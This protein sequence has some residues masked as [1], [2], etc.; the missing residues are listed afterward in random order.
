M[1]I[2]SA[3]ISLCV[4]NPPVAQIT[5]G[6]PAWRDSNAEFVCFTAAISLWTNSRSAGKK[7]PLSAQL[8]LLNVGRYFAFALRSSFHY[9]D[10]PCVLCD[11]QCS[12]KHKI[13]PSPSKVT[14]KPHSMRSVASTPIIKK[15]IML[16]IFIHWYAPIYMTSIKRRN[17]NNFRYYKNQYS[18]HVWIIITLSPLNTDLIPNPTRPRYT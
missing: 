13:Q 16:E 3:W 15:D 8:S 17:Q 9:M 11:W 5:D 6:F 7:I 10:T 14:V 1:D 4:E 18:F 2:S 12:R